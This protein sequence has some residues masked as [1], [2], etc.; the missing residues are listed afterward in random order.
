M[1]FG[2]G[3]RSGGEGAVMGCAHEP[4]ALAQF[5]VFLQAFCPSLEHGDR[6][7]CGR[8]ASTP[9]TIVK[10]WR[11]LSTPEHGVHS[12]GTKPSQISIF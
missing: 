10:E 9:A 4:R 5:F 8:T 1:A 12:E 7:P 3:S 6:P 11:Q 2:G